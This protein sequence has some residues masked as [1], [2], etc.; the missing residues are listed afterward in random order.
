MKLM[1]P[2]RSNQLNLERGHPTGRRASNK[3]RALSE[4]R[5]DSPTR[6]ETTDAQPP[7]HGLYLDPDLN[8]LKMKKGSLENWRS[9][10][11]DRIL[12]P[13]ISNKHY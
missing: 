12:D 7:T 4:R 1:T 3:L 9:L 6:G 8:K 11:V 2:L 5:E 13:I 10:N